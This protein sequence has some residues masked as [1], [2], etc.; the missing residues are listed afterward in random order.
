LS[1]DP[2]PHRTAKEI[3]A[4]NVL[5]KAALLFACA[6]QKS[7]D[8]ELCHNLVPLFWEWPTIRTSMLRCVFGANQKE[9]QAIVDSS[10]L[11]ARYRCLDCEVSFQPGSRVLMLRRQRSI[12]TI[13]KAKPGEEFVRT[14][15]FADLLCPI[16]M[17]D[18]LCQR[19]K[20]IKEL[21]AMSY[22]EYLCSPEWQILREMKLRKVGYRCRLCPCRGPLDVHHALYSPR[23][24]EDTDDLVVL[25]RTCHQR[26]H[27]VLQEAS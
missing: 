10:D 22:R 20:R 25:C 12:E 9:L 17:D 23:G 16:C 4:D 18:R 14:T 19:N 13:R 1:L 2:K 21:K 5:C 8:P 24:D 15:V 11:A 7:G 3:N 6:L 26:H 27:G